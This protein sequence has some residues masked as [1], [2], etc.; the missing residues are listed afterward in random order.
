MVIPSQFRSIIYKREEYDVRFTGTKINHAVVNV[1]FESELV[2]E[3][4]RPSNKCPACVGVGQ[5]G[6]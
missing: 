4:S 3:K 5:I 6:I 1:T 2:Q